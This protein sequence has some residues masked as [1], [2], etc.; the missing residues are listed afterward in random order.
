MANDQ[1]KELQRQREQVTWTFFWIVTAAFIGA[2]FA[3]G[4]IIIFLLY[5]GGPGLLIAF[6]GG[7]AVGEWMCPYSVCQHADHP[8]EDVRRNVCSICGRRISQ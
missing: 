5:I 3:T 1:D 7:I 6:Y 4:D 2:T 8:L